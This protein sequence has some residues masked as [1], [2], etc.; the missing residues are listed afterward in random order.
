MAEINPL[1]QKTGSFVLPEFILM[2]LFAIAI[3]VISA[4]P[5]IGNI[6]SVLFI[7]SAKFIFYLKGFRGNTAFIICAAIEA[8]PIISFLPGETLYIVVT[9]LRTKVK[10]ESL[11]AKAAK[12]QEKKQAKAEKKE[13][14]NRQKQQ[15]REQA[16][17]ELT[18][19]EK[20]QAQPSAQKPSP[21]RESISPE[22]GPVA[23]PKDIGSPIEREKDIASPREARE[24]SQKSQQAQSSSQEGSE[25][26]P[27]SQEGQK[28]RESISPEQGP[29]VKPKQDEQFTREYQGKDKYKK[30]A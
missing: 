14:K 29:L 22:Q 9:F 25:S 18:Q 7:L 2:S 5:L 8:I 23:Q 17:Y 27:L 3:G 26:Q 6:I 19:K 12:N 28:Q 15:A 11:Q 30:A 10:P 4:V 16:V 24:K 1:K 13:E 20:S 21:E